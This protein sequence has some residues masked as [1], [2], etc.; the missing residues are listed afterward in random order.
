MS[1]SITANDVGV[2]VRAAC[3]GKGIVKIS[4][5]IP[6]PIIAAGQLVPILPDYV[7][8]GVTIWAV[9]LSRNYQLPAIRQFIDFIAQA[10]SQD[11]LRPK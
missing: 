11:I 7:V 9:Y 6:N 8:P 10:W 5:D 1:G 4:C 3:R 2:L